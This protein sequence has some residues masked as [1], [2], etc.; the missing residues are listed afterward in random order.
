MPKRGLLADQLAD[1]VDDVAE[2]GRVAGAV[3]EEDE[4]GVLGE[5]LRGAGRAGQQ[6]H[7]AAALAQLADDV[8]LDPG[9]DPDHVRAVALEADRLGRGDGAGEVGAVHRGLGGDPLARLGL[10]RA[11]RE[12]PAPHRAAVADVADDGAGVDAADPRH[13]AVGE[14]VEPAALGGGDVLAVLR[15]AHDD[16]AGVGAVGLHRRRRDP[17]VADQRDR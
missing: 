15:L 1:G 5:H 12:D 2:R 14:P 9:V 16:A 6:R 13:A 11:G 3:G 17:V 8:E 10:G 7:L 4:V